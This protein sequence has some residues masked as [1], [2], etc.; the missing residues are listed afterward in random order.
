[1]LSD[2]SNENITERLQRRHLTRNVS[3]AGSS[4]GQPTRQGQDD[5]RK[6]KLALVSFATLQSTETS[7]ATA[8]SAHLTDPKPACPSGAAGTAHGERCYATKGNAVH[9]LAI[10]CPTALLVYPS[11]AFCEP[12]CHLCLPHSMLLLLELSIPLQV[13]LEL[14]P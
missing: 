8:E 6:L 7:K 11:A 4:T 5:Q 2:F 14:C 10:A 9:L 12:H 3:L 1:M 13:P